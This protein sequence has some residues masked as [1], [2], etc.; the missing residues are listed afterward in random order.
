MT[1][2]QPAQPGQAISG[3]TYSCSRPLLAFAVIGAGLLTIALLLF[4]AVLLPVSGKAAWASAR[5]WATFENGEAMAGEL[6]DIERAVFY[7]TTAIEL[8]SIVRA[9]QMRLTLAL[10]VTGLAVL[11][12]ASG[13]S[14]SLFLGSR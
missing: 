9:K 14:I 4:F 10:C 1:S 7:A 11:A 6:A 3:V 13:A 5:R 2:F 8:S 12:L